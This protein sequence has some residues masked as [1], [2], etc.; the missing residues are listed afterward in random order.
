MNNSVSR[1]SREMLKDFLQLKSVITKT[2]PQCRVIFL[3]PTPRVDNIQAVLTLHHLN[4]HFSELNLYAVDLS[5]VKVKHIFQKGLH[6]NPYGRG[7]VALNIAQKIR[8]LRC[9]RNT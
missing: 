5:N 8:S 3:Q 4:E 1:T 9:L 6:L 2:L 7:R